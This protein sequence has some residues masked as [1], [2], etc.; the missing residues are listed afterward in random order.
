MSASSY[1]ILLSCFEAPGGIRLS[2]ESLFAGMA[3]P[4]NV[5]IYPP[6]RVCVFASTLSGH[7]PLHI[8]S[9]RSLARVLHER[10][11]HLVYG[12]GTTGLMGELAKE[13]VRLGGKET[14]NG[15][16]PGALVGSEREVDK[17]ILQDKKV[18]VQGW[19]SR[20]SSFVRT[21]KS[22]N[23]QTS[24]P[25]PTNNAESSLLSEEIYGLTTVTEGL[26]DRKTLMIE[27]IATAGPNSGFI[28]LS[29][30]FGSLDEIMEVITARQ[31]GVHRRN[32]VLYNVDGFW[33]GLLGWVEGAIE[34]GFL[35]TEAR[36][37]MMLRSTA[38]QCVDALR[39]AEEKMQSIERAVSMPPGFIK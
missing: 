4:S 8:E 13:R 27:T 12:G 31:M 19:L 28:A 3:S 14:V 29:G 23:H 38:E 7:S 15:I 37:M 1:L 20:I 11:I 30:G 25:P 2:F 26:A 18:E 22:S 17:R 33:D 6:T 34:R 35:R 16:I 9:A 32:M 39:G 21:G 10:N 36:D 5:P 24:S